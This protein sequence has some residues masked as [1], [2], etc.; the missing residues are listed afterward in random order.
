MLPNNSDNKHNRLLL[1]TVAFCRNTTLFGGGKHRGIGVQLI[2]KS[3][4][5]GTGSSCAFRLSPSLVADCQ[6]LCFSCALMEMPADSHKDNNTK[7]MTG[8]YISIVAR[9]KY[10]KP[11]EEL[12]TYHAAHP[13]CDSNRL[14]RS[15]AY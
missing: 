10:P 1:I 9:L 14:L 15:F 11:F 6:S 8:E 12:Q 4:F 5:T 13:P 2:V 3:S 7:E